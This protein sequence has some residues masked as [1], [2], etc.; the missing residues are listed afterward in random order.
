MATDES[1][2]PLKA[3][4]WNDPSTGIDVL[5]AGFGFVHIVRWIDKGKVSVLLEE[6][7][8]AKDHDDVRRAFE[9]FGRR[10]RPTIIALRDLKA[11]EHA[12]LL[13]SQVVRLRYSASGRDKMLKLKLTGES[14]LFEELRVFL[15]PQSEI[16]QEEAPLGLSIRGPILSIV[17]GGLSFGLLALGSTAEDLTWREKY[18]EFY[19]LLGFIIRKVG[20]VGWSIIAIIW[21]GSSLLLLRSRFKRRPTMQVWEVQH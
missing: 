14:N 18:S 21:V 10:N 7:A 20:P 13:V 19:A 3:W 6:V 2:Q 9:K 16:R 17:L 8:A 12:A 4:S 11:V 1:M 5:V 15:S